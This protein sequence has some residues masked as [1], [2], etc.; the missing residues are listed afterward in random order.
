MQD[1]RVGRRYAQAL[2]DAARNLG[3]IDSVESDLGAIV[4]IYESD[5]TFRHFMIAPYT[6]RDEKIKIAEKLFADRVTALTMQVLR[7]MLMKGREEE[8]PVIFTEFVRLRREHAGVAHVVVTSAEELTSDQRSRLV[9]KLES[10]FGG[11]VEADYK[12][13]S[14]L[15]GGVRVAHQNSVFDG[16][17]RGGLQRLRERMKYD[18]L[19]QA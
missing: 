10:Q 1:R 17:V 15:I 12:V 8:M 14:R 9:A 7:V 16:S 11:K 19:K 18:L 13:D 2:F 3:V 6:S 4:N 5:E